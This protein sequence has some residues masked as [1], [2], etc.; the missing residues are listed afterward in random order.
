MRLTIADLL[1]NTN[2]AVQVRAVNNGQVSDWSPIYNLTTIQGTDAPLTPTGVSFTSVNDTFVATWNPVTTNAAGGDAN[3]VG[4]EM[5]FTANG[6]SKI[7]PM[8]QLTGSVLSYTLDFDHNRTLFDSAKAAVSFRVRA[9]DIKG[10]KSDWTI[11]F[12]AIN[13]APAPVTNATATGITDGIALA[14]SAPVDND[15][16]GYNIYVGTTAGFT[17]SAGNRLNS[18]P[19]SDTVFTYS[20]LTYSLQ[21]LKI[22]SVDKFG[23]ESG[24]VTVSATPKSPF[25]VDT[26]APGIPSIT[27]AVLALNANATEAALT[28]TWSL[29]S[30]PSDLA[31]FQIRYRKSGDTNWSQVSATKDDTNIVIPGLAPYIAYDV[32]AR[33]YDWSANYSNWSATTTA[34]ANSNTAPPQVTGLTAAPG[35]EAITYSWTDPSINDLS[36]YELTFSTSSTF[37]SGNVTYYTGLNNITISGLAAGATYYARVRAIDTGGLSG[38]FSATNT[39]ATTTYPATPLSDGVVPATPAAPTVLGGIG[40]LY[41]SWAAVTTNATGGAQNDVVTYEVH[42]STTSGFTPSG[43]T[44]AAEIAG[45]IATLD[46]NPNGTAMAYGTTYYVKIIAKDRDG[47]SGAS[48]QASGS[49]SKV[50]SLDSSLT[51]SDVGAPTTTQFNTLSGTVSSSIKGYVTEYSVNSSET[52]A[53]TTGW[54]TATPTR[55]P[56][57]F[58]WYRVTVTYNDTTTSTTNPALLTGNTGATGSQGIQGPAGADGT[59]LYTWLKYADTPTTGMSD[60]P[61]G[62]TYIGLAYNQASSTESTNYGDYQWSLIQGPQGIPG[63]PGADGQTTYTWVKYADNASGGGMTD[64]PTGKTYIGLAFN[65]T[66]ATESSIATDYQWSLIQGPQ[67]VAGT[68]AS[69]ISLT[70]TSQVLTSP[71]TGGA[72]TP[73]TTTVTGTPINTAISVYQYSSDGAAFTTTVPAG[74]SR[75][76]NVVTITG[77]TMTARTIAVRMADANGVADT[78]TVAKVSDGATG[79][80]GGTGSTG[81]AGADAYTVLLTNEAQVFAGSTTAALAGSAT[82]SVIAYKGTTQTA[83]TIGTITGQV[84]GLTTTITNNGTNNATVTITVTTSLTTK[85][86]TLTIPV[87]VG[88]QA[89]TKT[90]SWSLSLTGATGSQGIQG[91]TGAD[92]QTLY[93]WLKYADT[94]TSGM[95]DDPTG[96]TYMGLAYNK[97]SPTESVVYSDYTWSLIKGA[98]GSQGIQGPP[99]ADGSPTYTWIKYATSNTGAGLSDDPTG[100]SYIGIAYNKSTATESTLAS[101]YEWALIQGPQGATGATGATGAAGAPAA[102]ISLTTNAQVLTSPSTGGATTPTTSTVTGTATNTTISVWQYSVDGAAFSATVPAG[103]S[104]AG[105]VVTITGSTMTAKTI[106]VRM[107][108]A[109]G[110]ADTLTVARVSDGATG[111]TGSTGSTGATGAAGADGYT[112]IL[113]NEAQTFAGSTTAALAGSTTTAVVAYKGTAPIS[114]TI[115]TITGQVTGLT[116]AITNNGTTNATVTVTVTTSLTTKTGTLTIPITVDGKSFTK[117]FSW[118]LSLQG[119]TGSTGAT[120]SAGA[121]GVGVS[122]ITP[123]FYQIATG[124]AAPATPTTNPPPAPWTATEPAYVSNTELYRTERVLY[125]DST[126]A[127]TAVSKVSSYAAAAQAITTANGKNTNYYSTGT[128]GTTANV[129]GDNWFRYD[130][131]NRLIGQWRGTGGTGW[132]PVTIDNALLAS[133]IDAGKITAGTLDANRI[134]ANTITAS[135][136]VAGTIT[137]TSGIIA[138]AAITNA[139]IVDAAITT[140]KIGDAQITTAK[141]ANLAVTAAQIADATITTGKIISLSADKITAG[142][143]GGGFGLTMA[144]GSSILLNGGYLKSNT[145]TGTDQ[146]SNPSGQGFYLGNDGLRI[147]SGIVSA[148]AIT[149]GTISGTNTITLSGANAKI[150]GGTW[151]LSGSGLTIPNG[152]ISAAALNIQTGENIIHPKWADFEFTP[153]AYPATWPVSSATSFTAALDTTQ[154]KYNTTSL[155]L[156]NTSAAAR[157]AYFGDTITDYNTAVEA[158][159][160]YI[161]SMYIYNATGATV[162]A[163]AIIKQST[164]A[165]VTGTAQTIANTAAWVRYQWVLTTVASVTAVLAGIQMNANG[166]FY[167][168]GVQLEPSINT[169]VTTPSQWAPPSS[170]RIDGGMIR[171]GS[172]QSSQLVSVNGVNQPYWNIDTQGIAQFGAL[173]VRGSVVVGNVDSNGND[174]DAGQSVIQSANYAAGSAGWTLNSDGYAEFS[175]V[176]IRED[177]T[178]EGGAI[179]AGPSGIRASVIG[180]EDPLEADLQL[181]GSLTATG[182]RGET[183]TLGADGFYVY[184]ANQIAITQY[185]ITSNVATFTTAGP[186]GLTP[187]STPGAGD[188]APITID[189][190]AAAV[191][192]DWTVDTTPSTTTFTVQIVAANVT[193]TAVAGIVKGCDSNNNNIGPN[194][195]R[196]PTDGRNPNI[197]SGQLT[198]DNVTVSESMT[199]HGAAALDKGSTLALK[200]SISDPDHPATISATYDSDVTLQGLPGTCHGICIGHTGNYFVLSLDSS[201]TNYI[202]EHDKTTG[203][204]IATRF[205]KAPTAGLGG[206]WQVQGSRVDPYMYSLIWHSTQN[207]YYSIIRNY[208]Y[209]N[210]VFQNCEDDIVSIETNFT[211]SST[212]NSTNPNKANADAT[213]PVLGINY[214]DNFKLSLGYYTATSN[215]LQHYDIALGTQTGII[216]FPV[217]VS[218]PLNLS[219]SSNMQR[220]VL[221]ARGNFDIGAERIVIV[222]QDYDSTKFTEKNYVVFDTTGAQKTIESW[223]TATTAKIRAAFW[224]GTQFVEYVYGGSINKYAGGDNYSTTGSVTTWLSYSWYDFLGTVHETALS[225]W[226]SYTFP[227]RSRMSITVPTIPVSALGDPDYPNAANVWVVQQTAKPTLT[228]TARKIGQINAPGS[229]ITIIADGWKGNPLVAQPVNNFPTGSPATISSSVTD[230]SGPIISLVGDGTGRIGAMNWD[231]TGKIRFGSSTQTLTRMDFGT[232]G[233]TTNSTGYVDIPHSM[234]VVA[235][236]AIACMASFYGQSLTVNWD[237]GNS[238]ASMNR[239]HIRDNANADFASKAITITWMCMAI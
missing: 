124:S 139:M 203:A 188:G 23:Q 150:V 25:V 208:V 162:S 18:A 78:L 156:V 62:K 35:K 119:T 11:S 151:T 8:T 39:A 79:A 90:F 235:K 65:K 120:G 114:A 76:G 75:T 173:S 213:Q 98:D 4:Y 67:G 77:S 231:A 167:I 225:P 84:T 186:H 52:V 10:L 229:S 64:T 226:T 112:V 227:N 5:E 143:V 185:S 51:A 57:T 40:Y 92:G 74:V 234:G 30:P 117:T 180:S 187:A 12:P 237:N 175:H 197:I 134:G 45:T 196:F 219:S 82:T 159:T 73:A 36:K 174:L 116:T 202:S 198:A 205:T 108:D 47:A 13:P 136:L 20:T 68:P 93:T 9:V 195:I 54:S 94:P 210:G 222:T 83:A 55:T 192:S 181:L 236:T 232:I 212:F 147:D 130:G 44:K 194:Y 179:V 110:V 137:A 88:G 209:T 14:W 38:A 145:Y 106:A 63:T 101:D 214:I 99:G 89:F 7:V 176:Y 165:T 6:A 29:A 168:D 131:S 100:K 81:A 48:P 200:N 49:L 103:V 207:K 127:Y 113:T 87:T 223:P 160:R 149:A 172:I 24:D 1:P 221:I 104:R 43:S 125:T 199:I 211:I 46:K 218:A 217:S 109:N 164:G 70:A 31:G 204:Y 184:G 190:V 58:V 3:V 193:T 126:F 189:N 132:T 61:A 166:T 15:L 178:I 32:Q 157:I 96:K 111:A 97:T 128:P 138:D 154:K 42:T 239:F 22:R 121:T 216:G 41:V 152:G 27:S 161:L 80:T 2:Y 28:A 95:S 141:I 72:T 53:P 115:G 16:V 182:P 69:T 59:S 230:G 220:P 71:A 107:A 66:I 177:A 34:A 105:N 33:A 17:P 163:A 228:T 50:T 146:S 238:T 142:T 183:V 123:Y 233:L 91:P 122:S 56:G 224:N 21:Y 169:T 19:L 133:T 155:K 158:A 140:A 191:N 85:S 60:S 118:S 215:Q 26:T 201:G 86:G 102:I 148:S 37:A 135:K 170:T 206:F 144:A 171:T 129:A 153:T